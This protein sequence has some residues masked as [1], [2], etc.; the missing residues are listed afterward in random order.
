MNFESISRCPARR[1]RAAR[2]PDRSHDRAIQS[3]HAAQE[4]SGP[5]AVRKELLHQKVTLYPVESRDIAITDAGYWRRRGIEIKGASVPVS[6]I[7]MFISSRVA[8]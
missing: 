1:V 3:A 4:R 5:G 2:Q 8:H 7:F 6:A